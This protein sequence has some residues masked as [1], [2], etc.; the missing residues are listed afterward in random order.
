MFLLLCMLIYTSRL[1]QIVQLPKYVYKTLLFHA[2]KPLP[3][4]HQWVGNIIWPNAIKIYTKFFLAIGRLERVSGLI[5]LSTRV[6]F[7]ELSAVTVAWLSE[8]IV[9]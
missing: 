1:Q 9:S 7:L 3:L 6:V 8:H 5:W 4:V 2:V